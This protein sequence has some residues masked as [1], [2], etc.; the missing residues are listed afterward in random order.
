[1]AEALDVDTGG[2]EAEAEAAR[3][4]A[5]ALEE[6]GKLQVCRGQAFLQFRAAQ[7]GSEQCRTV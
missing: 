1:M 4:A 5:V 6:A 2:A 3:E 7:S